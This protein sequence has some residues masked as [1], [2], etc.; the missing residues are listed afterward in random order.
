MPW[1]DYAIN[2]DYIKQTLCVNKARPELHCE[3][4]CY[5]GKELAKNGSQDN[6]KTKNSVQ[7]IIDLYIPATIEKIEIV[8][9]KFL[10][11]F[12]P[13]YQVDYFYLYLKTVFRPPIF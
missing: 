11:D 13:T 6:S 9:E 7:K 8:G 1:L 4:K 2:Q 3:G 5:L 10:T 12:H